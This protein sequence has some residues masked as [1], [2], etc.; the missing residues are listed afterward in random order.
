MKRVLAMFLLAGALAAPT[1]AQTTLG[2]RGTSIWAI[3]DTLA[4]GMADSTKVFS[5]QG[6]R[7]LSLFVRV[8]HASGAG[9]IKLAISFRPYLV[10]SGSAAVADT[11]AGGQD[12]LSEQFSIASH[13]AGDSTGYGN[14]TL[15]TS[16][17]LGSGEIVFLSRAVLA[18]AHKWGIQG[19]WIHIPV[20]APYGR[21]VVRMLSASANTSRVRLAVVGTPY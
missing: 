21:V 19:G 5:C 9:D 7:T 3:D 8:T 16:S 14:Y 11:L 4:V 12:M 1:H 13:G 10:D 2:Q 18:L 6:Y 15:P 17:Q 20:R